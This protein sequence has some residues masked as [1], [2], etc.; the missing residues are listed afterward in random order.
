MNLPRC[1]VNLSNLWGLKCDLLTWN[2]SKSWSANKARAE[3]A[4]DDTQIKGML[5]GEKGEYR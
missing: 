4:F 1:F 3:K 5:A 2:E